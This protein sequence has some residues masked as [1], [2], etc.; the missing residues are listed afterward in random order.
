MIDESVLFRAFASP[1]VMRDQ[2]AHLAELSELP[3]IELRIVLLSG[4]QVI[5]TGAFGYFRFPR[6]HGVS[7]PDTVALEHMEGTTFIES[8]QEVNA[9]KIMFNELRETAISPQA[10]R[11]MLT[12]VAHD[13]WQ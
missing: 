13:T 5:A 9:Y 3:N 7:L 6:I 2:L 10:S 8:E 11:D 12:R 4:R 1:L